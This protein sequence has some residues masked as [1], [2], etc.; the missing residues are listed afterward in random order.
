MRRSNPYSG[1]LRSA[2]IKFINIH[3]EIVINYI[4]KNI[5]NL[6]DLF[7]FRQVSQRYN[8]LFNSLLNDSYMINLLLLYFVG[9]ANYLIVDAFLKTKT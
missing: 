2:S 9:Q 6:P 1:R 7:S 4:L 8:G 3:D 5:K